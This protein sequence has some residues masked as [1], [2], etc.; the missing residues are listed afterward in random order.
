MANRLILGAFNGSMVLRVSRP[1]Y[2]VLDDSL[3][4]SAISFDSRWGIAANVMQTGIVS[5]T[6]RKGSF[7]QLWA[8]GSFGTVAGLGK[9]PSMIANLRN[10][11][12][13]QY[14]NLGAD[15]SAQNSYNPNNGVISPRPQRFIFHSPRR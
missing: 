13:E 12:A 9:P 10:P 7:S 5:L 14:Q 15:V 2:N 8:V 1:G 6:L 4:A 3:P 11:N